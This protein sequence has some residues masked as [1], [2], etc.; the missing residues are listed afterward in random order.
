MRLELQYELRREDRLLKDLKAE[1]M[2][3]LFK[4]Q[5]EEK[6]LRM[7][8]KHDFDIPQDDAADDLAGNAAAAAVGMDTPAYGAFS[9]VGN[10]EQQSDYIAAAAAAAAAVAAATQSSM[11]QNDD[12]MESDSDASSLSGMSSSSSEDEVQDEEITRG[13]LSRVLKQYLPDEE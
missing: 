5:A 7:I 12:A 6:L 4:L 9:E 1:I 11:L 10:A 2:D 13:A 8:V 3:K